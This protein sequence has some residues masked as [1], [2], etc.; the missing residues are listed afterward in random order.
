MPS[1][2]TKAQKKL[3]KVKNDISTILAKHKVE[4]ALTLPTEVREVLFVGFKLSLHSRRS[5]KCP[6]CNL[7]SKAMKRANFMVVGKLIMQPIKMNTSMAKCNFE[8]SFVWS[9][10]ISIACTTF[11]KSFHSTCAL[12]V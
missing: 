12:A 5:Q 10:T 8:I 3:A 6:C 7:L 2:L 4:A 11:D 1:K 9:L